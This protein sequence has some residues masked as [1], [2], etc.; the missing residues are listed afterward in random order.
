KFPDLIV[1]ECAGGWF[2]GLVH[3]NAP[4][5]DIIYPHSS[6]PARSR[7]NRLLFSKSWAGKRLRSAEAMTSAWP[8]KEGHLTGRWSRRREHKQ[9]PPPWM[10]D[11]SHTQFR[12][13]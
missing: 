8:I 10:L 6:R 7:S 4:F 9:I 12:Q 13:P 2:Y 3:V 11:A 5:S 1:D